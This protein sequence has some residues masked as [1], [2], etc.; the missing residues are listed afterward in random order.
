MAAVSKR[1]LI[2]EGEPALSHALESKLK[3]E[4]CAVHIA[5]DG[6]QGLALLESGAK[7]DVVLLDIM[8]PV[9][10]GFQALQQ[11]L[12]R[13]DHPQVIV[14]SSMNQQEG[15]QRVLSLGAKRYLVK[16]DTSLSTLVD[17]VKKA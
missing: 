4:D 16:A 1:I 3:R 14:L 15:E 13:P 9:A 2:I 17:E 10:D 5:E 8:M 6:R 12:K 7:F 11:V